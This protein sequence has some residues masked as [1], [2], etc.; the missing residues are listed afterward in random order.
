MFMRKRDDRE[1][2]YIISMH[3]LRI[4]SDIE[5]YVYHPEKRVKIAIALATGRRDK[6]R[7]RELVNKFNKLRAAVLDDL[8]PS[9]DL[10]KHNAFRIYAEAL[11]DIT[12]GRLYRV[13]V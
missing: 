4:F 11:L 2:L 6:H 1:N 5:P 3:K 10:C 7:S 12:R 9:G 8:V 13:V